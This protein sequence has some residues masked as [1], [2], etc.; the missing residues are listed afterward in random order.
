MWIVVSN[1]FGVPRNSSNVLLKHTKICSAVHCRQKQR[2][3]WVAPLRTLPWS[4]LRCLRNCRISLSFR[5][6]K[7]APAVALSLG[8]K[9][10]KNM[11]SPHSSP[12]TPPP[13]APQEEGGEPG[14]LSQAATLDRAVRERQMGSVRGTRHLPVG[15]GLAGGGFCLSAPLPGLHGGDNEGW[16]PLTAP[17][18]GGS[19]L[20][21]RQS[22]ALSQLPARDSRLALKWRGWRLDEDQSHAWKNQSS[23]ALSAPPGFW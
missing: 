22:S 7:G 15:P 5:A 20:T 11:V 6:N 16:Q 13:L 18:A 9:T 1:A 21:A 23:M 4:S 12:E 17:Y 3:V 19:A 14:S 8:K 2:L 10:K